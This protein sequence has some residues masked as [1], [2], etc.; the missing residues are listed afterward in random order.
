LVALPV[1]LGIAATAHA[2]IISVSSNVADGT[3]VSVGQVLDVFF[4]GEDTT[5]GGGIIG[6]DA[7][8]LYDPLEIDIVSMTDNINFTQ[9]LAP[10]PL[11]F[12]QPVIG[13]TGAVD[14]GA[15]TISSVGG[16]ILTMFGG[17]P[18]GANGSPAVLF[19]M[20]IVVLSGITGDNATTITIAAKAGSPTDT[21]G[22]AGGGGGDEG[23]NLPLD[24]DLIVPEPT[25]MLVLGTGLVALLGLRR[26]RAM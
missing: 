26:R 20:E 16:T 11:G 25:T 18:I 12:Q 14:D 2:G 6:C 22:L 10:Y 9:S 13:S 15:G 1:I 17:V 4:Y 19:K 3:L 8:V 5:A 24:I 23:Q 7:R 21:F